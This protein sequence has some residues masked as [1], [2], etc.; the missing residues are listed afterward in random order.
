M[1]NRTYGHTKS[2]RP[3]DDDLIEQLADDAEAGYDPDEIVG[4]RGKRGRPRLGTAPSTVE[5][6]R[7]DPGLKARLLRRAEDEG[8]AVSEVIREA[9]RHHLEAS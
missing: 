7:L 1:T 2:G 9:L 3:V 6:V 4:R 5:S 8:V